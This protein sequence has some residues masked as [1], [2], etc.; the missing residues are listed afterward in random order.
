MPEMKTI[1]DIAVKKAAETDFGLGAV[2]NIDKPAGWT[3]FDVVKKIRNLTKVKKVG[4]AGTL[5]PFATG[6]LIVCTGPATKRIQSLMDT[7]KEYI[8]EIRLGVETD[9]LDSTGRITAQNEGAR[10]PSEAEIA[11][12]LKEFTG[13]ITQIPPMYSALKVNGKRLYQYA[14]EGKTVERKPR[15]IT[16]FEI[17]LIS[18]EFPYVTVRVVCSKGTYIRVLAADIGKK[19]GTGGH[20]SQLRRTRVG[21]FHVKDALN[22]EA[23]ALDLKEAGGGVIS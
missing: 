21:D 4:H 23:F 3:S 7:T 14:R 1:A 16:I 2:L 13:N 15:E 5:D 18:Y 8:G 10:M 22:L 11:T 20:L 12:V 19:L 9:T 6:V 17:E